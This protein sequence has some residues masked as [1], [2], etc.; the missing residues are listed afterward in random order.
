MIADALS[1]TRELLPSALRGR[2]DEIERRACERR[3][4][5][6]R[7]AEQP[8]GRRRR[9]MIGQLAGS[10]VARDRVLTS[11]LRRPDWIERLIAEHCPQPPLVE[12]A[13][14]SDAPKARRP[15]PK[16]PT[17]APR[18]GRTGRHHHTR[19]EET[20]MTAATDR[21]VVVCGGG[22]FIGGHLSPICAVRASAASG[23]ST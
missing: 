9:W 1:A 18:P 4:F 11:L 15:P 2:T 14:S 22:G 12:L 19:T 7:L 20:H 10:A 13:A 3:V 21:T 23:P 6:R 16:A 8:V 17:L 5:A